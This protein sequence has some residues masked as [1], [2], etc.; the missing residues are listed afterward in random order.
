MTRAYP[1]QQQLDAAI[2]TSAKAQKE[3]A[4]VP[5]KERIQIGHRFIVST[6][7]FCCYVCSSLT[8][9]KDEFKK[10][11]DEVPMELTLQMGR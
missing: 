3:W 7:A 4:K 8:I 10:T 9:A 6:A 2:E 1:S 5:L 11:A